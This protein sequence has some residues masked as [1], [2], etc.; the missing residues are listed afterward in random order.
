MAKAVVEQAV[1]VVAR[2]CSL[3]PDGRA[4]KGV[5]VW[6]SWRKTCLVQDAI[7]AMIFPCESLDDGE[8]WERLGSAVKMSEGEEE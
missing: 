1:P 5:V 4:D 6:G 8:A 2:R 3:V 7:L